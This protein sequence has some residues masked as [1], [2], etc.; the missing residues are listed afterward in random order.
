MFV[1][2]ATMAKGARWLVCDYQPGRPSGGTP[3]VHRRPCGPAS[4]DRATPETD[5][6]RTAVPRG[7]P[8]AVGLP[9]G[10]ALDPL[11]PRPARASVS[12]P[13]PA[14]GLQ[15]AAQYRRTADQ[16]RDRGPGQ[17]D[18]DLARR[19]AADRLHSAA[20]RGLSRDRQALRAGRSRRLRLLPQPLAVLP[21][22]PALPAHYGRLRP[23]ACR[24]PGAW[25]TRNWASGR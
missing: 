16:S 19:S 10:P 8:G 18:A 22:I 6:R 1:L 5:G 7:R 15:Q 14:V 13:A 4:P 17:A 25:L 11:R 9:V 12:L 3:C 24:C 2:A 21:G 23:R 20:L